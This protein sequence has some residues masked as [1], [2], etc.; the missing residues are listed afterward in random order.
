MSSFSPDPAAEIRRRLRLLMLFRALFA[1][2]LLGAA[3]MLNAGQGAAVPVAA[4]A[5]VIYGL[6]A[7]IFLLTGAYA[8]AMLRIKRL[9]RFAAV[10]IGVDSLVATAVILITG[11]AASVFSFLYLLVII[12][13]STFLERRGSMIIAGLCSFQYALLLHVEYFG[14]LPAWVAET[15]AGG[16]VHLWRE[17]LFKALTTSMGCFAVAFFS[18]MLADQVRRSRQTIK[19]MEERVRR[20][21]KLAYMGEMAAGMAHELKNPLAALAGSIQMLADERSGTAAFDRLLQIALRETRQLN[22][23]LTNFLTFARPPAGKPKP[24]RLDEAVGEIV[25]LFQRDSVRAGRIGVVRGPASD[26]WVAMDPV[27]LRQV[28]WNLLLNAADA[29]DG[30]GEIGVEV[31]SH[32]SGIARI[33]IQDTGCGMPEELKSSIFD[34]FFTTKAD[35]TGLG[36]PMVHRI[37]ESYDGWLTVDSA[38]DRGSVF[39]VCLKQIPAPREKLSDEKCFQG[40]QVD[41]RGQI[42]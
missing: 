12:C 2:I 35:G 17:V 6:I 22:D 1:T 31:S 42:G 18:T 27:H 40:A 19:R 5:S 33:R 10:Q 30:D 36:L 24:L 32:R 4:P 15:A 3:T 20:M 26:V 28:L 14:L 9:Q 29:I 38:P 16:M 8:V 21:E 11:S 25:A 23:L 34:P 37:L 7:L 13:S 39:T 41:S